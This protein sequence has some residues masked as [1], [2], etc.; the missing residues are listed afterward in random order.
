MK[1]HLKLLKYFEEKRDS[2]SPLLILTHD[3]PDPDALASA[4]ALQYLAVK[5]FGI[6]SRIV[7]GGVIGRNENRE[8]VRLLKLPIH[9]VKPSDLKKSTSVA[10]VDTQPHFQNNSFPQ[11][12]KATIVIDQHVSK[13][14]PHADLSII[15]TKCGATS[16]LLAR[17]LLAKE[18]E[19]PVRLA[20]ALVYGILSDTLNF[21]RVKNPDIIKTYLTLLPLSDIRAL[22]RIQNPPRSKHFFEGL[23]R[24][25]EKAAIHRKLIISHLGPVHSPDVV[26]QMAD[27]LLTYERMHW[28]FCTG[29]FGE[30]LHLSLRVL[31]PDTSASEILRSIVSDQGQ[32]GGHGPI[33]GGRVHVGYN[34]SDE[35]WKEK[36]DALSLLLKKKLK[37]RQKTNGRPLYKQQSVK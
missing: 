25:I 19:I 10:L 34:I 28:S 33:A 31:N 3:Y 11:N 27:F 2:L 20:T 22:A 17:T 14:P 29:R 15:D 13:H 8:M 7:Y 6:E 36:E 24:G 18:I 4:F 5:G 21:F 12:R 32:A 26:A 16:V 9:P 35:L 23:V 1:K 37:I 30:N